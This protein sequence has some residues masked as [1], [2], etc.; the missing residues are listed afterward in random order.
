MKRLAI[1]SLAS[2]AIFAGGPAVA[3]AAP[4]PSGHGQPGVEC[5]EDGLGPGPAGFQT[6]GFA[7]AETH[8]AGSEDSHSLVSGNDHAVSQYDVACYQLTQNAH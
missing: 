7:K 6:D 3:F 5:N 1:V 4:N 2:I 8:Y